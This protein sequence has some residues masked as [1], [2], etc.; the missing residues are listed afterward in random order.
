MPPGVL[1]YTYAPNISDL[2]EGDY[3]L[4]IRIQENTLG[5]YW[6]T[7]NDNPSITPPIYFMLKQTD[8]MK[9]STTA[10]LYRGLGSTSSPYYTLRGD[11]YSMS[12]NN[13]REINKIAIDTTENLLSLVQTNYTDLLNTNVLVN[14]NGTRISIQKELS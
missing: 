1:N 11:S 14:R 2:I 6:V 3:L 8:M 7:T 13:S 5:V 9:F 10:A 12:Y 4:F